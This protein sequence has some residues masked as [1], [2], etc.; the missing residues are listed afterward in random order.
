MGEI[1]GG[2]KK[3][4]TKNQ[5]IKRTSQLILYTS[6]HQHFR[7]TS[8]SAVVKYIGKLIRSNITV[9]DSYIEYLSTV[10]SFKGITI[11]NHLSSFL[12]FI[13]WYAGRY[14]GSSGPL[15]VHYIRMNNLIKELCKNYARQYSR[16]EKQCDRSMSAMI[17]KL[18]WPANGRADITDALNLR[19]KFAISFKA[20]NSIMTKV[21]YIEYLQ[22]LIV[23]LYTYAPQGRIEAINSLTIGEGRHLLNHGNMLLAICITC[24]IIRQYSIR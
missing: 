3:E 6:K 20:K 15:Y 23:H 2:S 22:F 7:I 17:A 13:T 8:A 4:E 1:E 10:M 18:K 24:L 14:I 12:Y 5:L 21:W 19:S 9:I 16:S 11:K